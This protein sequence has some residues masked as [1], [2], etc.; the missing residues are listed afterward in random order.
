MILIIT[1]KLGFYKH[2]QLSDEDRKCLLKLFDNNRSVYEIQYGY[3]FHFICWYIYRLVSF[4]KFDEINI[5][6]T[7]NKYHNIT[8][9]VSR[10]NII[11]RFIYNLTKRMIREKNNNLL[12]FCKEILP[13]IFII[14]EF[15]LKNENY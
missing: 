11:N 10:G 8:S 5:D 9:A 13:I 12:D 14:C 3:L 15:I 1:K 6:P 2:V 4:R 7:D